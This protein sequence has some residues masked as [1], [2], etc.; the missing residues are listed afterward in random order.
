MIAACPLT[1]SLCI[2]RIGVDLPKASNPV[3]R[4]HTRF[5]SARSDARL[6][7]AA[8]LDFQCLAENESISAI[9]HLLSNDQFSTLPFFVP[10][11]L[12]EISVS[13]L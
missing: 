8:L 11:I 3:K 13:V 10:K 7:Q 2:D 4:Q 6:D 5:S 9:D 1:S 12:V